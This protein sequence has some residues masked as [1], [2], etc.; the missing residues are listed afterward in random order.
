MEGDLPEETVLARADL[1]VVLNALP[2]FEGL[3]PAV[4]RQIAAAAEWLSLPGGATLFR[5]GERPDAF[6][7][8]LSGCLGVFPPDRNTADRTTPERHAPLQP[9]SRVAAGGTVGE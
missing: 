1:G 2:L 5:A 6:Y 8:V 9:I 4:L 7:V 3:D